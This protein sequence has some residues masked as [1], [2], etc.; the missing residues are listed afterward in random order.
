MTD[1]GTSRMSKMCAELAAFAGLENLRELSCVTLIQMLRQCGSKSCRDVVVR[2][3][4]GLLE[5]TDLKSDHI[6]IALHLK[7]IH[8]ELQINLPKSVGQLLRSSKTSFLSHILAD[9]R[10]NQGRMP[11]PVWPPLARTLAAGATAGCD[12]QLVWKY[13]GEEVFFSKD[14]TLLKRRVGLDAFTSMAAA[15]GFSE[16]ATTLLLPRF[17]DCLLGNIVSKNLHLSTPAHAAARCLVDTARSNMAFASYATQLIMEASGD[18]TRLTS[19]SNLLS[20]LVACID[21]KSTTEHFE[22]IRNML[23]NTRNRKGKMKK[24]TRTREED[25]AESK[26]RDKIQLFVAQN[27]EALARNP[28]AQEQG[29]LSE[30]ATLLASHSFYRPSGKK[31]ESFSGGTSEYPSVPM[32]GFVRSQYA[33]RVFSIATDSDSNDAK[34]SK[35]QSRAKATSDGLAPKWIASV[36]KSAKDLETKHKLVSHAGLSK[37]QRMEVVEKRTEALS[38]IDELDSVMAKLKD[39]NLDTMKKLDATRRVMFQLLLILLELPKDA[40]PLVGD[41]TTCL[42]NIN[43]TFDYLNEKKTKKRK[44]SKDN[45]PSL[46]E[47]LNVLVEVLLGMLVYP[48]AS[49][50]EAARS[51]FGAWSEDL[52]TD[53]LESLLSIVEG[54]GVGEGMEGDDDDDADDEEEE[55]IA[56][57]WREGEKEIKIDMG[58]FLESEGLDE[59][60]LGNIDWDAVDVDD[61]SEIEDDDDVD[62]DDDA[63]DDDEEEADTDENEDDGDDANEQS[64]QA[65]EMAVY[66]AHL[67]NMMRLRKEKKKAKEEMRRQ[68]LHFRL[69][70]LDFIDMFVAKNPCHP[71]TPMLVP[72]LVVVA[73]RS[74]T[75]KEIQQ[76][77]TKAAVV[78]KTRFGR[79][80]KLPSMKDDKTRKLVFDGLEAICKTARS[81]TVTKISRSK[82]KTGSEALKMA[83]MG[84]TYL[85][86]VASDDDEGAKVVCN[87]YRENLLWYM[88]GRKADLNYS[89]FADFITVQPK[90]ASRL[91]STV[92]EIA[93]LRPN[94]GE[95]LGARNEFLRGEACMMAADILKAWHKAFPDPALA[96]AELLSHMKALKQA[97]AGILGVGDEGKATRFEKVAKAKL[98]LRLMTALAAS[99]KRVFGSEA[100]KIL[101]G[102]PEMCAGLRNLAE[103]FPTLKGVVSNAI[104]TWP[105]DNLPADVKQRSKT[106]K[107]KPNKKPKKRKTS[108]GEGGLNLD[109]DF[110]QQLDDGKKES[111]AGRSNGKSKRRRKSTNSAKQKASNNTEGSAAGTRKKKR[112]KTK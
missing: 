106:T 90:I 30:I 40:V 112:K 64:E 9:T 1:I 108:E 89:F 6:Y 24:K 33:M 111:E 29:L 32:S 87:V 92:A 27:L 88:T 25:E 42:R 18:T 105:G 51:A 109:D 43:K 58:T 62:E 69:R 77:T 35:R 11:H 3:I 23:E 98:G 99:S 47:H 34:D 110:F 72:S 81:K 53:A 83:S 104:R 13:L 46:E 49:T 103:D 50:R 44:R 39:N 74:K 107:V 41:M 102:G 84:L 7:E 10:S 37:K 36:V 31:W 52:S 19:C 28:R 17:I 12:I 56:Q 93:A 20:S 21:A 45:G 68:S 55:E 96:R 4:D 15:I 38:A 5:Q 26:D 57:A 76:L 60:D 85:V 66:T 91:L 71:L 79:S 94:V 95:G 16:A 22:K 65:K 80:S 67:E 48:Q 86:R 2:A 14:S 78:L 82:N 54:P 101:A 8:P 70:A 97:S 61:G 73:S 100:D 59:E 75:T 63:D